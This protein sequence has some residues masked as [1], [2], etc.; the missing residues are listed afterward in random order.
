MEDHFADFDEESTS[1]PI[2]KTA[3]R[4][5]FRGGRRDDEIFSK[6]ID[7]AQRTFFVDVKQSA[8]GKFLKISEKS[9][10][11][12]STV[13]MDAEDVPRIISAL[14]EAEKHL[15]SHE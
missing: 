3:P 13:M 5:E 10:G 8:Q 6:R 4:A 11:K 14:N 2:Q 1:Q 12:K 9:R 15:S 7:A